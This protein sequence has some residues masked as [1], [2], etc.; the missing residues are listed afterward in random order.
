[1]SEEEYWSSTENGD[2]AA[3]FQIFD[4]DGEQDDTTK[5]HEYAVFVVREWKKS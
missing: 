2:S 4:E 5:T 3:F 1:M